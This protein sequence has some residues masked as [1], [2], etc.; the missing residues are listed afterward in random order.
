[1]PCPFCNIDG[2][3]SECVHGTGLLGLMCSKILQEAAKIDADA[4]AQCHFCTDPACP[5]TCYEAPDARSWV[6][7]KQCGVD[8]A[9]DP[10]QRGLLLTHMTSSCPALVQCSYG[11]FEGGPQMPIQKLEPPMNTTLVK[12][13]W[14]SRPFQKVFESAGVHKPTNVTY[15]KMP[16][17]R[18]KYKKQHIDYIP[19]VDTTYS[20]HDDLQCVSGN[21]VSEKQLQD[22]PWCRPDSPSPEP[23]AGAGGAAAAVHVPV[24]ADVPVAAHATRTSG[25]SVTK[26]N[27]FKPY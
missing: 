3:W 12:E 19:P 24:A 2:C 26:T 14:N 15:M 7:C 8:Y 25:R 20:P 9:N 21:G 27:R 22:P 1:M 13:A 5:G 10:V 18:R 23:Q 11:Q 16:A 6:R 4:A 17:R